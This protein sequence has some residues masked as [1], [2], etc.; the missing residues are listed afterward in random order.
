MFACRTKFLAGFSASLCSEFTTFRNTQSLYFLQGQQKNKLSTGMS[1][2]E[3]QSSEACLPS[4]P[5]WNSYYMFS[6]FHKYNISPSN[7]SCFQISI[8][9]FVLITNHTNL[10]YKPNYINTAQGSENSS[11]II[12]YM[13]IQNIFR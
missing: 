9:C 7:K 13:S 1:V 4:A 2:I 10:T 3:L 8:T 6:L 12:P 5:N 11:N